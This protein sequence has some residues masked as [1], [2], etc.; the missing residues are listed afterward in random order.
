MVLVG[1]CLEVVLILSG[2]ASSV[3]WVQ[4][5]DVVL[6]CLWWQ[7]LHIPIHGL[8]VASCNVNS[9]KF[10]SIARKWSTM[11]CTCICVAS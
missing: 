3:G 8:P 9:L 2:S 10:A 7:C 6:R 11:F 1:A 5:S 4:V